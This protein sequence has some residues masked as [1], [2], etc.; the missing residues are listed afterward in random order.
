MA[1]RPKA[2]REDIGLDQS[3]PTPQ[4][5]EP[6]LVVIR[7]AIGAPEAALAP[8]AEAAAVSAP[9]KAPLSWRPA[10]CPTLV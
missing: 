6:A 2:L 8:S 9:R 3:V 7:V 4:T 5:Q 10:N 1:P